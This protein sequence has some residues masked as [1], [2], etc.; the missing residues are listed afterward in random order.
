MK[1]IKNLSKIIPIKSQLK[2]QHFLSKIIPDS[3]NIQYLTFLPRLNTWAKAHNEKYH[4]FDTRYQLYDY[5]N[6]NIINNNP[7][8][9]FE[10][11][12][13][14][15]ESIE[16][17]VNLNNNENSRF[18]GFDSFEGLPQDWQNF[19]GIMK[20]SHFDLKG[21]IPNIDDERLIFIK[22]L[23][24]DKLELFL[25]N[26]NPINKLV[27]HLDCDLYSSTLY[28]LTQL[29]NNL[30]KGTILIF[31]EFNTVICEFRALEDYCSAFMKYYKIIGSTKYFN[32]LAIEIL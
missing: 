22:G 2:I 11:G 16:Y 18:Y 15:G 10:F 4:I 5:L 7:I 12:V 31:D 13:F 9:F 24:Q 19:S 20:K 27:I 17:W 21:K 23:F 1:L 28:V 30:K 6:L 14:E 8:D 26:Y 29:H 25:K 3:R 32:R